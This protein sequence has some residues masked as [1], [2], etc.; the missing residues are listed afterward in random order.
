MTLLLL[1]VTASALLS[2][3][4]ASADAPVPVA[5]ANAGV[6]GSL[7]SG[8]K[9]VVPGVAITNTTG[10][11]VALAQSIAAGTQPADL[12]GSADAGVNQLLLGDANG[13]KETWFAAFARNEIV[14]QYSP[15]A[16]DPHAADFAKA[17]AGQEPWYQPLITGPPINTCRTSPD[18]DPS[19]YYT[20]FVLQLAAEFYNLPNLKTQVLGDDR[21]PAQMSPAC[22]ADGKTLANGGL[23]ISFTYLSSALGSPGTPF[24][25]LPDQVNLGDPAFA[26]LYATAMFTNSAGQTFHGGVIRPSIAPIQGS[27]SPAG[28]ETVLSYIFQN[29]ASLLSQFHF[30]SSGLYAGGDP[31]TIPAELRPYFD[32][33]SMQVTVDASGGACSSDNFQVSGAG[34]TVVGADKQKA[35]QCELTL[36]VTAGQTGLRDLTVV[37]GK[38]KKSGQ[39][40]T[41]AVDLSQAIPVVP[42]FLNPSAP[43]PTPPATPVFNETPRVTIQDSPGNDLVPFAPLTLT[44]TQL[45]QLPAKTVTLPDG[46]TETGPTLSSLLAQ[47][48]FTLISSCKND[49][50]HY[51][52]EAASLDGS[53]AAISD[54]ELDPNFG[55]NQAILSIEENGVPLAVPRLAVPGDKTEARDVPDVFDI[56]VGRAAQQLPQSG[57]NTGCTPPGYTPLATPPA[58]AGSVLIN[59]EVSSPAAVVTWG[60]LQARPQIDQIDTFNQGS[61][62]NEREEKG[63]TLYDVL[64]ST[65]PEL[66]SVPEDDTRLYVEATSS[67]DGASALASWDELDPARN[68]TQDLLSLGESSL[69]PNVSPFH[70]FIPPDGTDTG[71]RLTTP[72]DVRGG[73]YD[74]GVQIVTVSRVPVVPGP[75]AGTGLNLQGANIRNTPL[76]GAYLVG[77][78]IQGANLNGGELADAFLVDA[79]LQGANLNN[80]DLA[81]AL[82]NGADLESA[83]LHGADLNGANL[84]A[85]DLTGANLTGA[86]LTGAILTGADLTGANLHGADLTNVVW[87]N[88]TCPDQTNSDDHGGTCTT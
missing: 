38:G 64:S 41:N 4:V 85:A 35:G 74:F 28:G 81:G 69:A 18:A 20:L 48:G 77:A 63:P 52:I 12:F 9:A 59:G 14:M 16:A 17:A 6:L 23:D 8:L 13:N 44:T 3:T 50:L 24:I 56:T 51:W 80:A 67:E 75:A 86:D 1:G 5:I 53:A 58:A 15:S 2:G 40:I 47:A 26:S 70:L 49:Q 79:I 30:L 39:T 68:N 54:G 87:S 76:D 25:A 82:L 27:A 57:G 43:P 84:T 55:N 11:S 32:L 21:N 78:N 83:N 19:G 45:A 66:A 31:T 34:V 7:V 36:D 37:R 88:T 72:G 71:P 65:E 33:R 42:D 61:T 10:G 62:P 22:S 29:Q 46:T 60:Q 73:R